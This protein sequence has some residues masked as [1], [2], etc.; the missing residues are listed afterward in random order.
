MN[1]TWSVILQAMEQGLNPHE[2]K[3]LPVRGGSPYREA[4]FEELNLTQ[5]TEQTVEI[6]PLYRFSHIFGP[7]LDINQ[8]EYPKLREMMFD[9]FMHDQN[10]RDLRQGLTKEEFYVRAILR[11]MLAGAYGSRAS[12]TINL[13]DN[14]E[15]KNLLYC[16]LVMFK[17][18]TS[19]DLFGQIMRAVYPNALVY[20]NNDVYREILIFLPFLKKENDEKKLD[21]LSGLF[22]DVNYTVFTFWGRHFGVIGFDETLEFEQM[23]I[24]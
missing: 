22:L 11:D 9:S 1:L 13:L 2:L 10:Q 3:F 15:A 16:M 21:L 6:N 20:R 14:S 8:T 7:L 24:F 12:E 23:L 5:L 19:I 17:N 18:G 4:S